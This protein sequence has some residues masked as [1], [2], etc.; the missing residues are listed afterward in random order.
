MVNENFELDPM[1][2]KKGKDNVIEGQ[3]LSMNLESTDVLA[4]FYEEEILNQEGKLSHLQKDE[5]VKEFFEEIIKE[6]EELDEEEEK[7]EEQYSQNTFEKK[8]QRST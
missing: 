8:D 7:E 1:L 3:K 2:G 6:Q 4:G 5:K